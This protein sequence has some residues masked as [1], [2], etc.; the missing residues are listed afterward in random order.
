MAILDEKGG[1][2]IRC[3]VC[4]D[5]HDYRCGCDMSS[6]YCDVCMSSF[7]QWHDVKWRIWVE[8]NRFEGRM[9]GGLPKEL[10][11]GDVCRNCAIRLAPIIRRFTDIAAVNTYNARLRKAINEHKRKQQ[12]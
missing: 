6:E 1:G 10:T 4:G 12:G 5:E 8:L 9:R 3:D 7:D 11:D 2:W